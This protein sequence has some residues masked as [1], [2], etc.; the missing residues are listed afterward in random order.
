MTDVGEVEERLQIPP[1]RPGARRQPGV[2]AVGVHGLL[3]VGQAGVLGCSV[4]LVE[5]E[6][7]SSERPLGEV[8]QRGMYAQPAE[9]ALAREGGMLPTSG[10]G[11]AEPRTVLGPLEFLS[12]I[13][14]RSAPAP[15]HLHRRG[16]IFLGGGEGQAQVRRCAVD[17][18]AV[19]EAVEEHPPVVTPGLELGVCGE[20]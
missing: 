12:R 4:G 19:D 15:G 14:T 1:G 11:P 10:A 13:G 3:V 2:V 7:G 5:P 6:V 17:L 16:V 20:P 18:V 8:D 9:Y